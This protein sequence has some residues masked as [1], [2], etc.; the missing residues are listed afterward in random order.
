METLPLRTCQ[1]LISGSSNMYE[2][3]LLRVESAYGF[4]WSV[5]IP[6]DDTYTKDDQLLDIDNVLF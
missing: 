6:F 5:W 3:D 2:T 1:D 4:V